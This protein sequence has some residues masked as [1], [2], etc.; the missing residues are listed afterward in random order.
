VDGSI[1]TYEARTC[2]SLLESH[3]RK[4]VDRSIPA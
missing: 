2:S 3:Q 4:L 1:P